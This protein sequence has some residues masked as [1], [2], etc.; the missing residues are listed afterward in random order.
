MDLKQFFHLKHVSAETSSLRNLIEEPITVQDALLW[1]ID[2]STQPRKKFLEIMA[3]FCSDEIARREINCLISDQA[4]YDK[5]VEER[6][7]VVDLLERFPQ[8]NMPF[9]VFLEVATK[10]QPRYFT[11]S[12]SNLVYPM[13]IHITVTL[14]EELTTGKVFNGVCSTYLKNL[15]PGKDVVR[16]FLR[17]STF[18]LPRDPTLPV[19]LVG[20]GTGIA[21][22]R[23]FIQEGFFLKNKGSPPVNWSLYFGCRHKN[24]DYIYEEELKKALDEGILSRLE[25]ACSRDQPEKVYVQHL[26]KQQG[27]FVWD[28]VHRKGGHVYVCGGTSMGRDVRNLIMEI[29]QEKGGMTQEQ[30]SAYLRDLQTSGRFVQELWG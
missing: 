15:K 2:I 9:E 22:M 13:V 23:A 6:C 10:L 3:Q 25:L 20:P 1:K 17:K 18:E 12:S 5:L 28:V 29:S 24:V 30:A 14:V 7:N 21:P 26:L 8:V 19:I 27:E 16:C 4:A 11:I